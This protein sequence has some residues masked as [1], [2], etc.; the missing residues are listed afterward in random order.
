L[1][2]ILQS[3]AVPYLAAFGTVFFWASAFPAARYIL[4]YYSPESIMLFR[5]TVAAVVL[6]G[7]C[8]VNKIP[9]P[10]KRDLPLFLLAG[11]VGL[12]MYS[13]FS[14]TGISL[15]PAGIS[16]FVI[17][18]API[19]TLILSIV[20][21]KEKA[22]GLI[23]VGVLVSLAGLAMISSTQ[24]EGLQLNVGILFL[25][26]AAGCTST[27]NIVQK[28]IVRKYTAIQ[29][30]AYS[31][32]IAA[33]LMWV[34]LPTLV[35]EFPHAPMTANL[36]IVFL[37]LFPSAIAYFLWGFALSR[38]EKTIYVSSFIYLMPFFSS[39]L[40]FLWLGEEL[41]VLAL[42]G[43]GIII[44]GMVIT[45]VKQRKPAPREERAE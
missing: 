4:Q 11:F 31:F 20:F 41:P 8:G 13:W 26:V 32:G 17:S 35:R 25:L 9:P 6:L 24:M 39:I 37:G 14:V 1:K 38:A 2:A 30:S 7:Y 23:W 27:F 19:F 22:S 40:A 15:V 36:L 21:L 3:R 5:F 29:S 45:N 43:G 44:A 42:L 18:S 16:S 10:E 12:F 28:R 33:L 34:F